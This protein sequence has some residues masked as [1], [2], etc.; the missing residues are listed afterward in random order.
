MF[1]DAKA[2]VGCGENGIAWK[3]LQHSAKSCNTQ[4]TGAIK[5]AYPAD[6]KEPRPVLLDVGQFV[7]REDVSGIEIANW[8]IKSGRKGAV[9]EEQGSI[10]AR[11]G[12]QQTSISDDMTSDTEVRE[13][14]IGGAGIDASQ[15][16]SDGNAFPEVAGEPKMFHANLWPMSGEKFRAGKTNLKEIQSAQAS[17]S[18]R[19]NPGESHKPQI[20]TSDGL[21]GG[22][23]P[24]FY[25]LG[26]GCVI[27]FGGG[28][29]A[30]RLWGV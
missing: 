12:R 23:M 19:K 8:P 24:F 17:G 9:I 15:V 26:I 13:C 10:N 18:E 20:V 29:L 28:T 11:V 3:C 4:P 7:L 14:G 22:L 6:A 25:G 5:I 21:F 30:W 16:D 2:S 1:M 27:V